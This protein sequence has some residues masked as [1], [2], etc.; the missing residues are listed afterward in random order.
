MSS[1][2]NKE[3]L[4]FVPT[5]LQIKVEAEK[6]GLIMGDEGLVSRLDIVFDG[7]DQVDPELNLIKG[8]GGAL[9]REKILISAARKVIIIADSTKFVKSFSRPV[10]LEVHPFARQPVTERL[11]KIGATP[12]LRVLDKGYPFVT[13]NGNL[14]IDASFD[15]I[16][17]PGRMEAE[18]KCIPGVLEAG[19]FTRKPD[20]CYKAKQDAS[21]EVLTAPAK[22]R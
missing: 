6:S 20:L 10:P 8:G 19:I 16:P 18:L 1:L 22:Q 12:V 3:S 15:K 4:R 2:E 9:L 5:S 11:R 13:E 14:I 17:D 7:A 21:F